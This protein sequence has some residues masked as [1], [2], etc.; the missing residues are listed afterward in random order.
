MITVYT[1]YKTATGD[2]VALAVKFIVE[3]Y[4]DVY[5]YELE[6]DPSNVEAVQSA[7]PAAIAARGEKLAAAKV[8]QKAASEAAAIASAPGRAAWATLKGRVAALESSSV[9]RSAAALARADRART[10]MDR[11]A[12]ERARSKAAESLAVLRPL[13]EEMRVAAAL[14]PLG[15]DYDQGDQCRKYLQIL[16]D[17]VLCFEGKFVFEQRRAAAIGNFWGLC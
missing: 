16:E 1:P 8:A 2:S 12:V 17:M 11:Q 14:F 9:K 4:H 3:G 6:G 13:V 15:L 10:K 7:L 5:G